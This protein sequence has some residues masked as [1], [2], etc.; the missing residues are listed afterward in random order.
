[1]LS[2]WLFSS[3]PFC[4]VPITYWPSSSIGAAVKL[5]TPSTR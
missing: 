5:A 3:G 1:L 4:G 2:N